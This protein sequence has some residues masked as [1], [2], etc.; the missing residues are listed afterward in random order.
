MCLDLRHVG[1]GNGADLGPPFERSELDLEPA[2]E[3][4][5]V[6]PDPG[7]LRARVARNHWADSRE[8]VGPRIRAA[9]TAAFFAL[10]TPTHATGTPGGIWTM[11]SRASSPSSTLSEERSGTPITGRSVCAASTPGRAAARPAPAMSTCS[12]RPLAVRPYSATASGC[13]G[14]ERTSNSC[15]IPRASSS[16]IAACMRGRSDSEPTTM[17]TSALDM[18]HRGD[19]SAVPHVRERDVLAGRVGTL[20]CIRDGASGGRDAEDS[21][22]VRHQA[23]S[24][25]RGAGME[26]VRAG[27]LG[28]FDPVDR[29]SNVAAGRVCAGRK[30]DGDRGGVRDLEVDAGEVAGRCAHERSEEIAVDTR[31]ERLRLGIP[32][33]AVELEYTWAVVREHDT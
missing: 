8:A 3:L 21:A 7:H 26:D 16:S 12:P 10:S 2:R 14:A 29:R 25:E 23:I 9:R 33:P 13:R 5:L 18:R 1:C 24:L 22:A 31:Q 11:E 6:R 27:L 28:V 4:A 30:D 32:E 17:P 15:A 20:A 19:V